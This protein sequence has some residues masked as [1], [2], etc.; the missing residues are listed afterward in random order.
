[1]VT[2]K[3][4]QVRLVELGRLLR[5]YRKQRGLSAAEVGKRIGCTQQ[6]ISLYELGKSSITVNLLRKICIIYGVKYYDLIREAASNEE[7]SF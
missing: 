6:M 3:L 7:V 4:T 5:E 2:I 1:M